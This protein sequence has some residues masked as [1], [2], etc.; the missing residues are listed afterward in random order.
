[1]PLIVDSSPRTS[2]AHFGDAA[3]T[4]PDHKGRDGQQKKIVR[5]AKGWEE[6]L[7]VA[8]GVI[9]RHYALTASCRLRIHGWGYHEW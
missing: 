9:I 2:K 3:V 4:Q 5:I 1:M 6:L 7:H 8:V